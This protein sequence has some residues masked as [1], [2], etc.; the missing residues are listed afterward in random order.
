MAD[1]PQYDY[2]NDTSSQ[3]TTKPIKVTEQN[4][5]DLFKMFKK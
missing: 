2:D 4:A 3:A 1:L 5:E